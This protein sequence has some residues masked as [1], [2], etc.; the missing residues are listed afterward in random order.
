MPDHLARVLKPLDRIT[1]V[2][3]IQIDARI[4]HECACFSELRA[5]VTSPLLELDFRAPGRAGKPAADRSDHESQDEGD[6]EFEGHW[7][8][9]YW[10]T[11][12]CK[13]PTFVPVGPVRRSA[14]SSSNN[15]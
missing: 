15:V 11:S 7:L 10:S 1:E 8:L 5:H 14:P 6:D 9:G 2:R 13:S 3:L 12:T 4:E